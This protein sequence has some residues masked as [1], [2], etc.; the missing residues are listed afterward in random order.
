MRILRLCCSIIFMGTAMTA[1][2]GCGSGTGSL[3]TG[4]LSSLTRDTY[5]GRASGQWSVKALFDFKGGKQ[6][7]EP[8]AT[9]TNVG[10][11]LFGQTEVGPPGDCFEN[12][13]CG[14]IF[15][16]T[17]SGKKYQLQV[18]Y[19]FEDSYG[20]NAW[21]TGGL[22]N[23]NGTLYGVA[24]GGA[25]NLG[26]GSGTVYSLIPSSSG[27]YSFN[28]LHTFGGQ[29][30]GIS[31]RAGLTYISG[32]LYGTTM[33]GGAHGWGT[34]FSITGSGQEQVLYSFKGGKRDGAQ[35]MGPLTYYNG[36]LY[37]TTYDDGNCYRTSGGSCNYG[38]GG[39]IFSLTTSG[40]EKVLHRFPTR[41]CH[42]AYY[43]GNPQAGLTLLNGVFYGTTDD[44]SNVDCGGGTLYKITPSGTGFKTLSVG[45]GEYDLPENTLT[46]VNGNLVGSGGPVLESFTTK[47]A[48]TI[49]AH[50]PEYYG[51]DS[52]ALLDIDGNLYGASGEG[53]L[54]GQFE[55]GWVYELTP[56]GS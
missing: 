41:S 35:P 39:T 28:L 40:Q 12:L 10:S 46:V 52:P 13:A 31:P 18:I 4:T 54:C 44:G 11:D 30:D 55:C 36:L 33:S 32:T 48:A 50:A 2:A 25:G 9:L 5:H 26:L 1:F 24:S 47:G 21:P 17:P 23:V 7:S 20:N 27:K 49:I 42:R 45:A 56:P 16:L 37:G 51:F 8:H 53:N 38:G 29:G 19:A 3:P 22:T 34:V 6:G 15:E 43:A 14:E